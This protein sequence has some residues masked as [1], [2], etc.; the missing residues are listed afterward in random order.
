MIETVPATEK[1]LQTFLDNI[2]DMDR[3][4]ALASLGVDT[5]TLDMFKDAGE[6]LAIKHD[7][8]ALIGIGGY[9]FV[10]YPTIIG[11]WMLLTNDVENHKI[12]F[13]KWS[14]KTV[15]DLLDLG[16]YITNRVYKYNKLHIDYLKWLGAEFYDDGTDFYTFWIGEGVNA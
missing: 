2:R 3:Q 13:L 14:K 16:C 11:G 1:D 12:E 5:L 8:G 6:V 4:E 15:D 7:N 9:P 10:H